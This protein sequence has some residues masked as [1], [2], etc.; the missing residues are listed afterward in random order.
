M[1]G[2]DGI[3]FFK[4]SPDE[5]TGRQGYNQG[6]NTAKQGLQAVQPLQGKDRAG[7]SSAFVQRFTMS[8][9]KAVTAD[10]NPPAT[11]RKFTEEV[12]S[13]ELA[14]SHSSVPDIK[15]RL[16]NPD[17]LADRITRHTKF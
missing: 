4:G 15:T 17:V 8:L 2:K 16:S 13:Q 9:Y 12:N 7:I 10:N 3:D 5:D 6:E 14:L 1:S 11:I